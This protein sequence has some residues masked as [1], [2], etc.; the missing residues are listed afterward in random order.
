M[1]STKFICEVCG[2]E[3]TT[4]K[5][6]GTHKGL[7]H[8]NR[9]LGPKTML[10]KGCAKVIYKSNK[11]GFCNSCRDREGENNSFYNRV[12][13]NE[14]KMDL[15]I[16]CAKATKKMWEDPKYRSNVINGMSKPRSKTQKENMS[17]SMSQWYI[18]NPEQR[19]IRSI[20]MS[21]NWKLGKGGNTVTSKQEEYFYSLLKDAYKG[22]I[23]R[24]YHIFEEGKNFFADFFFPDYNT[25]IE[26][27]GTF[28]HADPRRFKGEDTIIQN[29]RAEDIWERDRVRT[30]CLTLLGYKIIVV[31]EED[32]YQ[33]PNEFINTLVQKLQ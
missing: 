7:Q 16:K 18:K 26:F 31:W 25:I 29:V 10:C 21:N 22:I 24:N 4:F 9:K 2:R 11:S 5:G 13:S 17:K 23:I 20:A 8:S 19:K 3:F 12:H 1:D 33:N 28:W 6:L 32:F 27:N 30:K 15:S 14:T